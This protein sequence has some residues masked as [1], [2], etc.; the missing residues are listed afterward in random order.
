M[1]REG[2]LIRWETPENE[3][4]GTCFLGT[5]RTPEG[6]AGL[7]RLFDSLFYRPDSFALP[8][9]FQQIIKLQAQRVHFEPA[10]DP[11]RCHLLGVE[12]V[13][14]AHAAKLRFERGRA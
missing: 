13:V 7:S 5:C 12:P 8:H 6:T 10:R 9:D 11:I 4:A 1:N 14:F 2:W 3:S